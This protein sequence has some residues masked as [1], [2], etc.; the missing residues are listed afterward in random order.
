MNQ[1]EQVPDAE[2]LLRL[3]VEQ[4]GENAL[5]L[6]DAAGRIVGWFPGATRT[7]GYLPHEVIGQP[8]SMLFTP[9]NIE[10]GMVEYEQEVAQSNA[11]AEGDRWMLRK[12]GGRFWATGALTPIHSAD[13]QLVGYGKILRDRTDIRIKVDALAKQNESLKEASDRK[14]QFI[15]TLSHELRNPLA[16]LS[17]SLE[18]LKIAGD[19]PKSVRQAVTTIESELGTMRRLVDDLIDVTRVGTGKVHLEKM[20]Q[21]LRPIVSAAIETCRPNTDSHSHRLHVI[22][23]HAPLLVDVDAARMKQVFVNLIQNA[24]KYTKN[25]GTIWVKV[26][27]E[28]AEAVVKIEDNGIGISP[29]MLPHIFELFTQAEFASDRPEAGLGIGLSVVKDLTQLHDG[30]VQVRSDGIGKGSEFTVRLP[31]ANCEDRPD[32]PG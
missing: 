28:A 7:F 8:V 32:S 3:L 26:S 9:E 2:E 19:D 23:P 31:M 29:D 5:L 16:A 14:N 4:L 12:D 6:L 21:D 13:G 25:G 18:L 10:A 22:L 20:C 1:G 11:E 15:S 17:M 30:S 24:A 27:V